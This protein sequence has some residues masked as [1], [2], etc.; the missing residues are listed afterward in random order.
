MPCLGFTRASSLLSSLTRL[1]AHL[2]SAH[3]V[4]CLV[5]EDSPELA[6]ENALDRAHDALFPF[7]TTCLFVSS[8]VDKHGNNCP[9]AL[10]MPINWDL[11]GPRIV[12]DDGI[13]IIDITELGKPRYG[14]MFPHD[15]VLMDAGAYLRDYRHPYFEDA[16]LCDEFGNVSVYAVR[17]TWLGYDYKVKFDRVKPEVGDACAH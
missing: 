12:N 13:T 5:P 2:P 17:S 1:L 7:I 4:L 8:T 11:Y 9:Q 3:C 15:N 14:F 16:R 10:L 6:D